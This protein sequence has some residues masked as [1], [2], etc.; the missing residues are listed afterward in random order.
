LC[1][2]HL[3][4]YTYAI[5]KLR[6]CSQMMPAN[7]LNKHIQQPKEADGNGKSK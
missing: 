4:G 1:R 7:W 5:Q 3:D 6:S 2:D